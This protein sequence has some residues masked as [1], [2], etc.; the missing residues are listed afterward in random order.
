[1][2]NWVYFLGGVMIFEKIRNHFWMAAAK[3]EEVPGLKAWKKLT[4]GDANYKMKDET[5][6]SEVDFLGASDLDKGALFNMKGEL[7]RA[8]ELGATE[9]IDYI[10]KEHPG[11]FIGYRTAGFEE[12]ENGEMTM[13]MTAYSRVDDLVEKAEKKKQT[14]VIPKLQEM[15]PKVQK[16]LP[17][18]I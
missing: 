2:E 7:A 6:K 18:K 16:L 8:V 17:P 10:A 15:A 14:H 3:G 1:M 12:D 4:R 9:R 13:E 5:K 11:A